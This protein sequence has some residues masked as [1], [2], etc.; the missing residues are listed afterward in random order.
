MTP[1]TDTLPPARRWEPLRH[2]RHHDTAEAQFC[3]LC[4]DPR[5]GRWPGATPWPYAGN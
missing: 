4:P 3:G 5:P 1:E 2:A